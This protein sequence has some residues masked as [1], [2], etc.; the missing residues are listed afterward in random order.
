VIP[1]SWADPGELLRIGITR[2]Q[3][4]LD[5]RFQTDRTK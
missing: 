1:G 4:A 5:G 2:P 3:E